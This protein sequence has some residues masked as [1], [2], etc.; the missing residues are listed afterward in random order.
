MGHSV[1]ADLRT[2]NTPMVLLFE[3][4]AGKPY[5]DEECAAAL[6]PKA[7]PNWNANVS[8]PGRLGA[9]RPGP[10]Q[11]PLRLVV[12]AHPPLYICHCLIPNQTLTSKRF[13]VYG[14]RKSNRR[15]LTCRAQVL[16]ACLNKVGGVTASKLTKGP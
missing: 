4:L 1:D 6:V 15:G 5:C 8:E 13:P 9:L 2:P 7:G 10:V 3:E 12:A 16:P 11:P 14:L